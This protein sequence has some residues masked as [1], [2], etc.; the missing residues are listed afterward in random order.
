[1]PRFGSFAQARDAFAV[2][3]RLPTCDGSGEAADF[4]GV[5]VGF[6]LPAF[7]AGAAECRVPARSQVR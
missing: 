2:S 3:R 6:A 1:M 4:S 7:D 5:F